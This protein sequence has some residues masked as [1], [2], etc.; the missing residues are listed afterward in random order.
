MVGFALLIMFWSLVYVLDLTLKAHHITQERYLIWHL[1]TGIS[2]GLLRIK[3]FTKSFNRHF[4]ILGNLRWFPW[5]LW[6]S[7]GVIF[8]F[9]ALVFGVAL[10]CLLVINTVSQRVVEH[11]VL[12]PVVS[13]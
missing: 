6:F 1:N 4:Q 8:T 10:L 9:I 5:K 13:C 3:W 2:F 11:E 7:I 12:T